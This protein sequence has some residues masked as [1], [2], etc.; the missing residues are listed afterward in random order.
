NPGVM[1]ETIDITLRPMLDVFGATVAIQD[2][3][4]GESLKKNFV[5]VASMIE[6]EEQD[7]GTMHHGGDE[8]GAD[9][10]GCRCAE[11]SHFAVLPS[12][13]G[14]SPNVP[15]RKPASRLS[16]TFSNVSGRSGTMTVLAISGLSASR[17]RVMFS[18]WTTSIRTLSGN[19]ARVTPRARNTSKLPRCEPK[20]MQPWPLSTC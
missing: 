8:N 5:A 9:R 4:L 18:L 17:K 11:E 15:T 14:R 16:F 6:A 1:L 10:K 2:Y 13:V 7:D 12:L 19:S 3:F 20:R